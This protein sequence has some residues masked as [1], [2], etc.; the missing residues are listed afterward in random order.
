MNYNDYVMRQW[1]RRYTEP[2]EN[3][4]EDLSDE[5]Y[6]E[7]CDRI[8]YEQGEYDEWCDMQREERLIE[9]HENR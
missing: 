7:L 1:E 8:D 9:E 6:E 3:P 5:E 4:Y 2:D